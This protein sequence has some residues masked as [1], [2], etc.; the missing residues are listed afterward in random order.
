ML[1]DRET[2]GDF[3]TVFETEIL[4]ARRSKKG[5][6]LAEKTPR[7]YSIM[8]HTI[9][10]EFGHLTWE[11]A[12][13]DKVA[14]FL[15][16]LPARPSNAHRS[17]MI[18]VWRHAIA[19]GK[20]VPPVNVPE[21]TIPKD[22][23]VERQPLTLEWYQAIHA[24]AEPWFQNAMDLVLQMLQRREDV[25]LFRFDAIQTIDGVRQ[26]K[27]ENTSEAGR[28]LLPIGEELE[29][30]IA[31]CRDDILSPYMVHRKPLR[32]RREYLEKKEH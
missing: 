3:L 25:V 6:A 16:A 29:A 13:L 23:V 26:L 27:T 9:G 19:K 31:R 15:V 32:K 17:L 5:K 30:L 21:M 1:G 20:V 12:A 7:E 2:I 22:H 10:N 24:A 11:A 4:P 18:Q 28:L 14:K 8:L